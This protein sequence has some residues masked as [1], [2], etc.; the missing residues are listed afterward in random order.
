MDAK[1][2]Y[3]SARQEAIRK[4]LIAKLHVLASQAGLD[5]AGMYEALNAA[6]KAKQILMYPYNWKGRGEKSRVG[7]STLKIWQLRQALRIFERDQRDQRDQKDEKDIKTS[8]AHSAQDGAKVV[9]FEE[10]KSN[11]GGKNADAS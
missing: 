3:R 11:K 2:T 4:A 10:W 8:D 1:Q 9:E 7:I 6:A 5:D